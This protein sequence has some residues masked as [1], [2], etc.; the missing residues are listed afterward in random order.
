[1]KERYGYNH[2][3]K[4]LSIAKVYTED[5]HP[6]RLS[7]IDAHARHIVGHLLKHGYEAYV[8]G[9]A[10]RDLLQGIPPKDFDIVTD[11]HPN[12][13]RRLFR[14]AHIVGKKFRIVLVTTRGNEAIEVSTFRSNVDDVDA[15]SS[16]M[17]GT[18]D[19]DVMR[20][21]FTCNALYYSPMTKEII[22]YKNGIE[23]IKKGVLVPIRKE[24]QEDPVR[25]LRALKFSAKCKLK[26]PFSM[27][28]EI[29]KNGHFIATVS[30][31]RVTEEIMKLLVS[32]SLAPILQLCF[33]YKLLQYMLPNVH[34]WFRNMKSKLAMGRWDAM[35]KYCTEVDALFTKGITRPKAFTYFIR[36]FVEEAVAT[37][38]VHGGRPSLKNLMV[39]IKD[40][41]EPITPPNVYIH[42]ALHSIVE[43]K[44]P[45]ELKPKRNT[46]RT[47][48][49][50]TKNKSQLQAKRGIKPS[51]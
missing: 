51:T 30:R 8:V 38:C 50:R 36:A 5:E 13:I 49:P 27:S 2:K 7:D 1:M 3:G 32:G 4:L 17:Y 34:T 40:W 42:E 46:R 33:K 35:H 24:F 14:R 45:K 20:R 16:A 6:I 11:A 12:K 26:I 25:M 39:Q 41:L 48:R 19:Q 9:G 29:R 28:R 18:M 22:D 23:D 47:R 10:I 37:Y 43:V 31:S 15:T 21:D 44:Q